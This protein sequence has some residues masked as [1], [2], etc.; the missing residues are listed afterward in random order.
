MTIIYYV[1]LDVTALL[2]SIVLY[3][4]QGSVCFVIIINSF[5]VCVCIPPWCN[6]SAFPEGRADV[7]SHF[8]VLA[9]F[10]NKNPHTAAAAFV[11]GQIGDVKTA[12]R[13][14]QDAE[15]ACQ[16]K[17]SQPSHT[18]CVLMNRYVRVMRLAPPDT[19]SVCSLSGARDCFLAR[20]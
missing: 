1:N 16:M 8:C 20:Q 13:Y 7:K 11:L 17:G 19:A 14:F 12:E 4:L 3:Y 5:N 6:E 10:Y 9:P 18:T 15:K 2:N